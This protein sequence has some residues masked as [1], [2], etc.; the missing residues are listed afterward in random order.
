[1]KIVD[2][3]INSLSKVSDK[4]LLNLHWRC[5]QLYISFKKKNNVKGMA[6]LKSKHDIIVKEMKKRKMKHVSDIH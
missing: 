2:I 4:E 5:H 1:M 3:N 6:L